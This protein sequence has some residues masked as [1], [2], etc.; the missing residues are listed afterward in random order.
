[1]VYPKFPDNINRNLKNPL[2]YCPRQQAQRIAFLN[3]KEK[4]ILF[5]QHKAC[6]IIWLIPVFTPYFKLCIPESGVDVFPYK[7]FVVK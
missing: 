7:P 5:H 6:P 1:M 2:K 4:A 3:K